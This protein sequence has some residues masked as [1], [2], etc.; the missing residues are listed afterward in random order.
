M[1]P[2]FVEKVYSDFVFYDKLPA[3]V[4][5]T[6]LVGFPDT[7]LVGAI[8]V[9]YLA[10]QLKPEEK[11][12]VDSS[13][14]PPIIPVRRSEPKELIRIY[15]R[16][17]CVLIVSEI[18]I[19]PAFIR[20]FSESL[21]DWVEEKKIKD[22]ICLT[23]VTEPRRIEI[24]T[25]KVFVLSADVKRSEELARVLDAEVF[26]EGFVTGIHA[27]ILRVGMR[28]GMDVS[29]L[30][31]Q[32]HLNYPD[33]GAAAQLLNRLPKLVNEHVDVK[34]LLESEEMVRMQLRDLMRRTSEAMVQKSREMELPPVYR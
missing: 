24:E 29:I 31:A 15:E 9:S 21:L 20:S 10:E 16:K 11:G 2:S 6:L 7:G 30:L 8:A 26:T 5:K 14:L 23:G 22:V 33:P 17:N 1:K 12:Y 25:P 18:P 19:P 3:K 34:Q 28:R 32:S 27:E 4:D 13:E